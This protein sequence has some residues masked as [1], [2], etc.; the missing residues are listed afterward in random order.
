MS[1]P[2]KAGS[3]YPGAIG[4]ESAKPKPDAKKLIKEGMDTLHGTGPRTGPAKVK[5]DFSK[6]EGRMIF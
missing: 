3:S 4:D 2:K 5:E 6:A 1:F